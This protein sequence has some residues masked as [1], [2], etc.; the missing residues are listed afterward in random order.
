[1]AKGY[2]SWEVWRNNTAEISQWNK[3]A[4]MSAGMK[5]GYN[6]WEVW[7]NNTAEISSWVKTAPIEAAMI[8]NAANV[9]NS[10]SLPTRTALIDLQIKMA[11]AALTTVQGVG[12][13]MLGIGTWATG[14]FPEEGQLFIAR[15]AGAEL[16]G[17][18]GHKT[19]VANNDQIVAAVSAGVYEAVSAAMSGNNGGGTQDITINLD[20]EVIYKNQQKIAANKGYNFNQGAFA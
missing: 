6:S 17:S 18:I 12:F 13:K 1:M 20:G 15:E 19:A 2:N 11:K 5:N 14:G 16:V 10:V 9:W 7:R 3:T 4:P 8:N